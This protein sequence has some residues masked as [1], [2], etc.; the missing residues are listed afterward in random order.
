MFTGDGF[1]AVT[2][3]ASFSVYVCNCSNGANY[4]LIETG[5]VVFLSVQ[6]PPW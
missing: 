4:C 2:G 3:N 1:V 6:F 5:C